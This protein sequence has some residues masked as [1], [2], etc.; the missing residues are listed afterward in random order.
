VIS[1]IFDRQ[2]MLH[3]LSMSN[4]IL[5]SVHCLV[6]NER[7]EKYSMI[8]YKT[9]ITYEENLLHKVLLL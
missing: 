5:Q 2:G 9:R 1:D 4:E 6:D 8:F 7:K 3:Y